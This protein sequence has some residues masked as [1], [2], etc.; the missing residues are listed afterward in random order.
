MLLSS[1]YQAIFYSDFSIGAMYLV[2][3]Q[4][5]ML[6]LISSWDKLK[7]KFLCAHSQTFFFLN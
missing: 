2:L 6:R 3:Q 7:E 1:F 4:K 5:T